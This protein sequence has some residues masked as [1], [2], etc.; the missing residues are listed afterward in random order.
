MSHPQIDSI[1]RYGHKSFRE[2]LDEALE[3]NRYI[4]DV[5]GEEI[6][7]GDEYYRNKHDELIHSKNFMQYAEEELEL[8]KKTR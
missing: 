8:H 2:L 3:E 1:Q 7:I 5:F 6:K 4:E